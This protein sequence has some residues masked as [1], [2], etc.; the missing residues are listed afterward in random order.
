MDDV[1][2]WEFTTRRSE[3]DDQGNAERDDPMSAC[4]TEMMDRMKSD[5]D[6]ADRCPMSKMCKGAMEKARFGSL[7]AI[8]GIAL[9]ILGA[10]ILLAPTVLVWFAAGTAIL[11]GTGMLV[12]AG[13]ASR[14]STRL[15]NAWRKG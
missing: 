13:L 8:M 4:C 2:A 3:M 6:E 10:L 15:R 7:L 11:L 14:F 12:L 5:S 9:L 1:I